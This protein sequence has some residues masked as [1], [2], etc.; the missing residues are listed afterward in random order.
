MFI[1]VVWERGNEP[2]TFSS[3]ILPIY[4][5]RRKKKFLF[6]EILPNSLQVSLE[7]LLS[8]RQ[9]NNQLRGIQRVSRPSGWKSNY[10]YADNFSR[11]ERLLR[12]VYRGIFLITRHKRLLTLR[13]HCSSELSSI[14]FRYWCYTVGSEKSPVKIQNPFSSRLQYLSRKIWAVIFFLHFR[15]SISWNFLSELGRK[16]VRLP[17]M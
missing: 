13:T 6:F 15:S 16:A 17:V 7:T 3:F 9:F 8:S 4:E 11:S 5:Y 10:K 12:V 14:Y 1:T 2:T